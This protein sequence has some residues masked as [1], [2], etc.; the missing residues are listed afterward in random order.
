M[1][2]LQDYL[3]DLWKYNM[4]TLKW[5]QLTPNLKHGRAPQS[6]RGHSAVLYQDT[7]YSL[8]DVHCVWLD[9]VLSVGI[10]LV[11]DEQRNYHLL[12]KQLHNCLLVS[13][14]QAA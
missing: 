4:D 13:L 5:K 6:R 7:M 2:V 9:C 10:Y 3:G 1:N 14:T 11:A 8:S 12:L